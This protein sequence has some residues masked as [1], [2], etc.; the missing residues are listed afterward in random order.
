MHIRMLPVRLTS[1]T[2]ANV[3]GSKLR[4]GAGDHPGAVH[5]RVDPGLF[6]DQG[7]DPGLIGDIQNGLG[8]PVG[9]DSN[10]STSKV[11]N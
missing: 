11:E 4:P 9:G 1:I 2:L 10:N 3:S 5:Q 7:V 8:H 6:G